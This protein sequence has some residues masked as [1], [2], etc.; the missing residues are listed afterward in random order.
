MQ[1]HIQR[2]GITHLSNMYSQLWSSKR[3]HSEKV[4]I[5][6]NIPGGN[7][8]TRMCIRE[9]IFIHVLGNTKYA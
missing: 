5:L 7:Y 3:I 8:V 6:E 1:Q 2:E 4:I 9:T